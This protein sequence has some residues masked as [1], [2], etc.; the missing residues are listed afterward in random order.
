MN[1]KKFYQ[2]S[3]F[4]SYL[5]NDPVVCE[6]LRFE[7]AVATRHKSDERF[8]LEG[9]CR[10]CDQPSTFL[11]DRLA[12]YLKTE[13]GIPIPNWR[14]RLVCTG[15]GLNNRQR[16]IFQLIKESVEQWAP[17]DNDLSLYAMEQITPLYK[18]LQRDLSDVVCIGSEYLGDDVPSGSFIDGVEPGVRHENVESLSFPDDSFD[19]VTSNDVLE[20][21]N[22]PERAIAEVYRVL[23]PGGEF[24]ISVPFCLQAD[25][26]VRRAEK[27]AAEI[28]HILP[29]VYHGNPLSSQG[30]LV[31]N[32]FGWDFLDLLRAA[33]FVDM[34][35]CCYWSYLYGHLGEPQYYFWCRKLA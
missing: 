25:C 8:L 32:D 5:A 11:V 12:S 9:Y 15:C 13:A 33:S 6:H 22:L 24:L 29:P 7:T 2:K 26:T 1:T 23:K 28:K 3:D 10:V 19:L 31:F 21:V 18:R 30:S 4:Q 20:H 17:H 27:T 35:M 16:A 14:E 34:V